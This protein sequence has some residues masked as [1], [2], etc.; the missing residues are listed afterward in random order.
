[1]IVQNDIKQITWSKYLLLALPIAIVISP[2]LTSL[3]ELF[4]YTIFITTPSLRKRFADSFKQPIVVFGFLLG[5]MIVISSLWSEA[6]WGMKSEHILSWRKLFLLPIAISLTKDNIFK[7]KFLL[8]FV[9]SISFFAL[10]SWLA[11]LSVLELPK[12]PESLLRNH[13]TQGM[14]FFVA[15]FSAASI[16]IYKMGIAERYKLILFISLILLVSNNLTISTSRSGYAMGLVLVMCLAAY[17]GGRKAVLFSTISVMTLTALLYLSPTSNHQIQ[18]IFKEANNVET[19][20]VSTSGG[21]RVIM[22]INTLPIIESASM[23]GHGLKSFSLEYARQVEG[24]SG[25]KGFVTGDPHNQYLLILS[26]QGI[27]GLIIFFAFICSCFFQRVEKFYKL[28]GVSVLL[29]WMVTSLF[30]GHFSASVEGK[31]IFLWC[32]VMFSIPELTQKQ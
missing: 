13:G 30:S 24:V 28:L 6:S 15:A 29:G 10:L 26:E 1:M 27:I 32:G 4:L 9:I 16:L 22:W 18:K 12:E 21:D 5:F 14:V 3:L 7:D 25:W 20:S 23:T 31:F 8:I 17:V 19:S 2:P 11:Y